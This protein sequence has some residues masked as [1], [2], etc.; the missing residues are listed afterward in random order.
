MTTWKTGRALL[1]QRLA[2]SALPIEKLSERIAAAAPVRVPGTAVYL[3]RDP[4]HVPHALLLN[5]HHNKVLHER[6]VFL[7]MSTVTRAYV[8]GC[9]SREG[10][11]ALA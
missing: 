5:M 10:R 9:R 2:E 6:I 8:A 1:A 7:G 3:T 4:S 11:A